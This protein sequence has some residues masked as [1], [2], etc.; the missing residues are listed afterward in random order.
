[1]S[2]F[3]FRFEFGFKMLEIACLGSLVLRGEWDDRGVLVAGVGP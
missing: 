2:R 1:M 3:G